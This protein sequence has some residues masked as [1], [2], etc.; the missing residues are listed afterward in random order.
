MPAEVSEEVVGKKAKYPAL[1]APW[2]RFIAHDRVQVLEKITIDR[3]DQAA[4]RDTV[5][6]LRG[7]DVAR[8][9]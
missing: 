6:R 4:V 5:A 2:R 3:A 9:R 1:A 7:T 8:R